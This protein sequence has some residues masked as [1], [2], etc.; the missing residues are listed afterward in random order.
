MPCSPSG[1]MGPV[2]GKK[3]EKE[4]EAETETVEVTIFKQEFS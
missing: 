2:E 1:S 4:K 3:T